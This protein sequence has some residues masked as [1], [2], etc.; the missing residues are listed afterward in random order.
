[1]IDKLFAHTTGLLDQFGLS[2]VEARIFTT[3]DDYAVDTY[4]LLDANGEPL[5]GHYQAQELLTLMQELL[6][7]GELSTRVSR[8]P[9]R[10]VRHFQIP[11]RVNFHYDA[12]AGRSIVEL[13]TTDN[14]GLLSQVGQVFYAQGV[15]LQ[16][17][18][19]ATFGSWAEDVFHVTNRDNQPLTD[20]EQQS[21]R[22]K[23]IEELDAD[24]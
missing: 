1:V 20:A 17:A 18:K 3:A 23:L 10:R 16:N 12:A 22:E 5:T 24:S 14:P 15:N 4:Q 9:A 8:P 6:T 19:V 13:I 21:L 2:I 7:S 11:T